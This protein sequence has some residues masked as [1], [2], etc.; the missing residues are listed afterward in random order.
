MSYSILPRF[1]TSKLLVYGS[2][3]LS[4]SISLLLSTLTLLFISSYFLLSLS[5]LPTLTSTSF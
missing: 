4:F 2:S 3:S 1:L 5:L